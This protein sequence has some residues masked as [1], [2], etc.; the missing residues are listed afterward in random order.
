MFARLA[1]ITFAL[2][3][4][5]ATEARISHVARTPGHEF[6]GAA[7][8]GRRTLTGQTIAFSCYGGGGD[9]ECP[10]DLNG[11]SG[12]LINVYPGYQ[13]AYPNGACTWDDKVRSSFTQ[14]L[15]T[16]TFMFNRLASCRTPN[17][18]TA[19][20]HLPAAPLPAAAARGTTMEILVS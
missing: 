11:E 7:T 1:I 8:L 20:R 10:T 19:L 16:L 15:Q 6:L 9:C 18:R 17:R 14:A 13:C 3:A 12:V 2:A 4:T 5:L